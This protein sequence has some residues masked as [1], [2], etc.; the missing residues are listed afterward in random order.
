FRS[1][2]NDFG[3]P[4]SLVAMA[5]G[6]LVV[7]Y[8]YRLPPYG[9]RAVVSEDGGRSWGPEIVVRDARGSWDLGYPN[10]VEA[11]PGRSGVIYYFTERDDTV[12][13]DGGVRHIARSLFVPE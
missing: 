11:A 13:A 6:R 2:V 5:D 10:A 12:Q 4:G 1:R 3:A 7:V 9:I 8:G